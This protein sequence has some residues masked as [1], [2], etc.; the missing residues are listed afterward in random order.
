M[1]KR[2]MDSGL[3]RLSTLVGQVEIPMQQTFDADSRSVKRVKLLDGIIWYLTKKHGANVHDKGIVTITS[4]S[5]LSV[6][7][8]LNHVANL[9]SDGF[10]VSR[11]EPGQWVCWDFHERHVRP[12]HYTIDARDLQSW[13]VEGSLDGESWTEIDRQADNQDFRHDWN[14]VSFTVSTPAECRFIRLTQADKNHDGHDELRLR[15][16]EFFGTLPESLSDTNLEIVNLKNTVEGLDREFNRRFPFRFPFRL[17]ITEAKDPSWRIEAAKRWDGIISY[18][19]KKH[20]G[21]V[22]DKGIVT[23]TSK[24][25]DETPFGDPSWAVKHVKHVADLVDVR[26][27]WGEPQFCSADEP[28]QWVCWDF[29]E[30]RVRPTHYTIRAY[31]ASLRS[32]VVEGSL[33]GARWAEIDR[34]T[35]NRDFSGEYWNLASFSVAK[36]AECRFIRLTQTALHWAYQHSLALH[37]VEFFGTLSE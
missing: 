1:L 16:V 8:G 9:I 33:D 32:W 11:R 28:D 25:I 6:H 34:Q 29:R 18:L 31:C 21:N 26:R 12:T 37:A 23:I 13:I 24:S 2:E 27:A 10:F 35:D 15:A 17:T 20:G 30:M 7:N 14:T 4:K 3:Q 19:T 5:V 22:H 36:P